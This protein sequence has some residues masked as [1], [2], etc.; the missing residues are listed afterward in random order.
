MFTDFREKG[1]EGE[2]GRETLRGERNI[3][4][5]PFVHAPTREKTYNLGMCPDLE[6][7]PQPF[8]LWDDAP[9]NWAIPPGANLKCSWAG[10]GEQVIWTDLEGTCCDTLEWG[11]CLCF[12]PLL[13]FPLLLWASLIS[14]YGK[15]TCS[16]N[17]WGYGGLSCPR[18]SAATTWRWMFEIFEGHLWSLL[19]SVASWFR[20]TVGRICIII[21]QRPWSLCF[22]PT[23][24]WGIS[25]MSSGQQSRA[26]GGQ[27]DL[28]LDLCLWRTL[29]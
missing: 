3:D 12:L 5:L 13:N 18:P 28:V 25:T 21:Q 14:K 20:H 10:Q 4:W 9:T 24:L 22:P 17:V 16:G 29:F 27:T 15:G 7:N 8:S 19:L 2:R 23:L 11:L 26:H 6:S 1:R